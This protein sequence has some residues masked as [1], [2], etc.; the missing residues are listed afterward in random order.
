MTQPLT[1]AERAVLIGDYE[2]RAAI[3]EYDGGHYRE[4]AEARAS[5][6]IGHI[7]WS[8]SILGVIKAAESQNGS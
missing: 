7:P 1:K 4:D 5:V 6:E 2:E 8:G 3:Y